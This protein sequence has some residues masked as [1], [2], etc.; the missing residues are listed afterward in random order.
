MERADFFPI[1]A[2]VI[3]P[4]DNDPNGVDRDANANDLKIK[5]QFLDKFVIKF[6]D[7]G[8]GVDDNTVKSANFTITATDLV[9]NTKTLIDGT[10]YTFVY[11]SSSDEVTLLPSSGIWPL[12]FT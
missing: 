11:N 3:D 6:S 5:N 4:L 12:N 7:V 2:Q 9:G 1:T 10:D 8:V